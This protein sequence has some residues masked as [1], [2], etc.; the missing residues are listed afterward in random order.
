MTPLDE[1]AVVGGAAGLLCCSTMTPESAVRTFRI[2]GARVDAIDLDT[3]VEMFG[4]WIE[5]RRREYVIL[6]GSHGVVEQ[7]GDPR[8]R[9]AHEEAG[10]VVPDGMPAVWLGRWKGLR[11]MD[12]VYGP[13]LMRAVCATGVERGWRHFLYGASPAVVEALA[14]R[15][16]ADYPGLE[17]VGA[18]SPPYRE[19]TER[20][21]AEVI[22][23]VDGSGADIVW[24]G[25]G[26]PKQDLWAAR[27]R[28]RL[29]AP[30]LVAVGAAFDFLAG[31][32]PMAPRWIQRSGLEWLFRL[33]TEPRRLWGRYARVVP[34]YA[35]SLLR[36]AVRR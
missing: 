34:R 24:I 12:R 1:L 7:R 36:E 27:F 10:L 6:T 28:P 29:H 35:L 26:V 8:L 17:V 20:E 21:E 19:L 18:F 2:G 23:L 30:I 5:K 33:T 3:T 11:G 9:E 4:R 14:D 13:D 16:R 15:L 25:L 31:N 32:K 22:A